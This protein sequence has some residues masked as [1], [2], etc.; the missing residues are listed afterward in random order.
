MG[1]TE[2]GRRLSIL[3][4]DD[5]EVDRER[6]QRMVRDQFTVYQ[7]AT[8]DDAVDA[9]RRLRPDCVLLDYRLPTASGLELLEQSLFGDTPVIVLTGQGDDAIAAEVI[10]AGARDYLGKDT[11][12]PV[13]LAAAIDGAV[14]QQTLAVRLELARRELRE[15]SEVSGTALRGALASIV[16]KCEAVL[17]DE[18]GRLSTRQENDVR[19]VQQAASDLGAVVDQMVCYAHSGDTR[20]A[21]TPIDLNEVIA[22][23]KDDLAE[24]IK[25]ERAL[26]AV[27]HLPTVRGRRD[28]FVRL[29]HEL[30]SNALRYRSAAAPVI[31]VNAV[32][33][34]SDWAIS[35]SDNGRGVAAEDREKIF[36]PMVR[37]DGPE[38]ESG[39]GIG[40]A[41]CR[42][43]V[44]L[45]GGS[46]WVEPAASGGAKFC[47]S[48]P[49]SSG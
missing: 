37:V 22:A 4:L 24:Q 39:S 38:V 31:S 29:F 11:L 36:E 35:V 8:V 42:R 15:V 14:R 27:E 3:V 9:Y 45:S 34:A 49:A 2:A 33:L 48:L 28:E 41:I 17:D 13:R 19:A 16:E 7:A 40:L 46:I 10:K 44:R 32:R 23:V 47:V 26:V 6:I 43:V 12:E 25:S 5:D 30:F 20:V 21:I 1:T 18:E